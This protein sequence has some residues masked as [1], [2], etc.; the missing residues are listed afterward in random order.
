MLCQSNNL[1]HYSDYVG[2]RYLMKAV[3]SMFRN[4][5]AERLHVFVELNHYTFDSYDNPLDS[6]EVHSTKILRNN[7]IISNY[8]LLHE[9]LYSG[10]LFFS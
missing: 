7:W 2:L 1:L 3:T 8:K 4:N 9:F 10:V 6:L 5:E